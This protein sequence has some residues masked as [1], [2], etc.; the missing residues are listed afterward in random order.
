MSIIREN[1]LQT[2]LWTEHFLNPL[3]KAAQLTTREFILCI[4]CTF[5]LWDKLGLKVEYAEISLLNAQADFFYF[6]IFCLCFYEIL[7]FLFLQ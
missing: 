7:D 6:F 1:C 2:L 5:Y 3:E 4:S